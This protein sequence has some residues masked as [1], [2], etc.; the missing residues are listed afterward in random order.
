MRSRPAPV[1]LPDDV[2]S[3]FVAEDFQAP[4]RAERANFDNRLFWQKASYRSD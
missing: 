4:A 3:G 2:V 1:T